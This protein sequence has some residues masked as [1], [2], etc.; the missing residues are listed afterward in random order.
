MLRGVVATPRARRGRAPAGARGRRHAWLGLSLAVLALAALG[1]ALVRAAR[2]AG[3]VW[4]GAAAGATAV[5]V[6]AW[7][8]GQVAVLRGRRRGLRPAV[9]REREVL[10]S[11][12]DHLG[13]GVAVADAGGRLTM[14]NPAAERILGLG[15]TDSGP[16]QWS[17][18][19][20]L[21]HPD[22]KTRFGAEEL[23]LARALAGDESRE[24]EMFVRNKALRAGVFISV[25]A[26]PIR[27]GDGSIR[28][29]VALFRD[30]TE[31]KWAETLLRDSEAR[32]RSIVE[33]T[34][35]ALL[36]LSH[37]DRILEF[38][39]EAER[40]FGH[41]R[42]EVLGQPFLELCLPVEFH[43]AVAADLREVRAGASP[44]GFETPV[45]T[46]D[47]RGRT[48]LWSFT[49]LAGGE[50]RTASI[51]A[52]GH[53][54]TERREAEETRRMRELAAHLQ[55]ARENERKHVAREIHDELGQ[56]L[57][58]LR[59]EVSA[60]ARQATGAQSGLPE[61]FARLGGMIDGTIAAVRRLAAEL[62][63]QIL[64]ELGLLEAIRWQT[65]EFESRSGIACTVELVEDEIHCGSDRAIAI[66]RILQESLTNVARHAGATHVVVRL[67]ENGEQ[68]V[69]EVEDDGR[70]ITREQMKDARSFGLLGMQE[71]ARM[72]GGQLVVEGRAGGTT[73]TVQMPCGD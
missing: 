5:W 18:L 58:G 69:L 24:V 32:F 56:A 23:P 17:E 29:A 27:A 54:I 37:D 3:A 42:F 64:D 10:E 57:T 2:S 21:F 45:Q 7:G 65:R 71:R 16:D 63:P 9:R 4:I 38:N 40:I 28:G 1:V 39:P 50:G 61:R 11:V 70:G 49:R 34:A 35:S 59:L 36:I 20:G 44:P 43:A 25:T 60:L 66:F 33:A 72:F 46:R 19:Y 47:G 26:T 51:I 48:I 53:D 67:R 31:R 73:V 13:D 22:G 14:F 12:L 6:A 68:I 41:R 55:S 52:T 62:R 8:L 15:L 30:I